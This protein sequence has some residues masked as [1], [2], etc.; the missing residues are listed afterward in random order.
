MVQDYIPAGAPILDSSLKTSQQAQP[1]VDVTTP[2]PTALPFD[3][4]DPFREGWG[5]WYFN[6]PQIYSDHILW[7]ANYVPAGT[8]LLTYTIVPSLPGQYHVLPA[9]AWEAYFPEVQGTSAGAA[10]EILEAK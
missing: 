1:S 3:N 2:T 6:N 4:A 10:F 9:H 5:W 8:Y 7:T